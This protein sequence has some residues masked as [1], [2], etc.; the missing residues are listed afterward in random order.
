MKV[1]KI[2][3][4]NRNLI[5]Y[6]TQYMVVC[7]VILTEILMLACSSDEEYTCQPYVINNTMDNYYSIKNYINKFKLDDP[8]NAIQGP[9]YSKSTLDKKRFCNQNNNPRG[10]FFGSAYENSST[11]PQASQLHNT[12]YINVHSNTIPYAL[13]QLNTDTSDSDDSLSNNST[14]TEHLLAVNPKKNKEM[15]KIDHDSAINE[16]RAYMDR[17]RKYEE[18]ARMLEF[19]KLSLSVPVAKDSA[20]Y[21]KSIAEMHAYKLSILEKRNQN[22]PEVQ[23]S[24]RYK[25][26]A[27]DVQTELIDNIN[28]GSEE[29]I[30]IIWVSLYKTKKQYIKNGF[31]FVNYIDMSLIKTMN[32]FTK[33]D[34]FYYYEMLRDLGV[35]LTKNSVSYY[36]K[37]IKKSSKN[38]VVEHNPYKITLGDIYIKKDINLLWHAESVL[39]AYIDHVIQ[40]CPMYREN[41]QDFN[42]KRQLL[43]ILCIPEI[44]EDLFYMKYEEIKLVKQMVLNASSS[45]KYI[46]LCDLFC[47]IEYIYGEVHN[48]STIINEAYKSISK[49][50]SGRCLY[51]STDIDIYT[52]I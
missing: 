20:Q 51:N 35:Y 30:S 24:F 2:K 5:P 39:I 32:L 16:E 15:C 17:K 48:D 41:I 38:T 6:S 1:T 25:A 36:N 8:V 37:D 18:T 26:N 42:L 28:N 40:R 47:I 31:L 44:Y 49:L 29:K 50:A 11:M 12:K 9:S 27:K 52:S 4:M 46:N 7:M 34:M 3:I 22:N 14:A 13:H 23:L 10:H 19:V 43:L 33:Y 21:R 45:L